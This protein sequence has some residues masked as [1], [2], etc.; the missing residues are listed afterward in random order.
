MTLV[1]G[2]NYWKLNEGFKV[3]LSAKYAGTK[4]IA[5]AQVASLD[6]SADPE[7]MFDTVM[8]SLEVHQFEFAL[9]DDGMLNRAGFV[10]PTHD[11]G[12]V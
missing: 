12:R 3:D 4:A 10:I 11:R 1:K 9:D 5:A 2:K 6:G 8:Q 7:A